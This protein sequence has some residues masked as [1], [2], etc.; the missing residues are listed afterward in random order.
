[1]NAKKCDRCEKFYEDYGGLEYIQYGNK[2]NGMSFFGVKSLFF[3]L[4]PD[5]MK[6]L[7]DWFDGVCVSVPE[8][9]EE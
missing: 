6:S 7:Y 1:M 5:C 3:D 2:Y 9:G 8:E 4:C